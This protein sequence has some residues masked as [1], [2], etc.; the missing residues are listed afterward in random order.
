[1][2]KRTVIYVIIVNKCTMYISVPV[3]WWHRTQRDLH[4][5]F[6][7]LWNKKKMIMVNVMYMYLYSWL[8]CRNWKMYAL[9][10]CPSTDLIPTCWIWKDINA[11]E[12]YFILFFFY[13]ILKGEGLLI[14]TLSTVSAMESKFSSQVFMVQ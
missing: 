14:S 3:D 5:N 8:W 1:M 2:S 11:F 9:F 10:L 4:Q 12:L 7:N 6:S 13:S